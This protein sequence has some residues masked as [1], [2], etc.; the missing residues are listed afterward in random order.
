MTTKDSTTNPLF[1]GINQATA[2]ELGRNYIVMAARRAEAQEQRA[3]LHD[4]L[5][6]LRELTLSGKNVQA[7]EKKARGQMEQLDFDLEV[8]KRRLQ[9]LEQAIPGRSRAEAQAMETR[10]DLDL[11]KVRAEIEVAQQ[12]LVVVLAEAVLIRERIEGPKYVPDG[13]GG[14]RPASPCR[15]DFS[16]MLAGDKWTS[17]L[18]E[19]VAS[20]QS[21]QEGPTALEHQIHGVYRA[22]ER[23]QELLAAP[24]DKVFGDLITSLGG[25]VDRLHG[26]PT[27]A[28]AGRHAHVGERGE[29]PA[30]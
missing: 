30:A 5:V 21:A 6:S 12:Q 22:K 2:E 27:C 4:D 28:C 16:N 3:A 18:R 24:D 8:Y 17:L 13:R 11:E 23:L 15:V 14:W 19:A 10:H 26:A 20:R 25:A 9:A 1:V 29:L 7:E